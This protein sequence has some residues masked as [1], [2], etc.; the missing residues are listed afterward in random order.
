M[1]TTDYFNH[2][3]DPNAGLKGQIFFVAL[4]N[5]A[6][7]E[8]IAFD[9]AMALHEPEGFETEYKSGFD[10]NCGSANCRG[11]VTYNDWKIT[12]LQDRYNGFFSWYI[13]EKIDKIRRKQQ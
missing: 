5:I 12:E 6:V 3:C 7:N 9:Y 4:R 13:Q 8:E 10:C 11:K 1:E 2:S